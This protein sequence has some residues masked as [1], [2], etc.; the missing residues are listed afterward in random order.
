MPA[1]SKSKYKSPPPTQSDLTAFVGAKPVAR[2]KTL[3]AM[4]KKAAGKDDVA[5]A[6]Q[7][8]VEAAVVEEDQEM[9]EVKPAG[10]SRVT[11]RGREEQS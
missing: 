2:Q 1:P 5:R 7:D 11:A 4:F 8:E 3:G 10:Q 9:E 6:V